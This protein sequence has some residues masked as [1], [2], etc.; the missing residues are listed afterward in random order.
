MQ[1][2]TLES[3]INGIGLGMPGQT[4]IQARATW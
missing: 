3:L 2:A 4:E 1:D